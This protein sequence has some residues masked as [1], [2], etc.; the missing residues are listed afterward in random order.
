[1]RE[2]QIP[3]PISGIPL[4]PELSGRQKLDETIIQS[5]SAIMGFDGQSRRL[6]TC[7]L[8]GSLHTIAPPVS[9]IVNVLGS[10]ASDDITFSSTPTSEVMIQANP[11]NSGD[12][13]VNIGAAAAV[14]TGWPLDAGDIISLSINN[15]KD[16]QLHIISSGD[17]VI[18]I[19]T[20]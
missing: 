15:L 10:G 8:N 18:I 13:W 7:A 6:L 5:L 17:K 9:A 16:L 1:M 3:F 4:K 12:V 20:V 2:I 19:R 11:G 14:D